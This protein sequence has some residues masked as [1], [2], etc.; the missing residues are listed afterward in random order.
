VN[1]EGAIGVAKENGALLSNG[2]AEK[3]VDVSD[4]KSSGKGKIK[5]FSLGNNITRTFGE[6][7]SI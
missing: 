5:G 3:L 4:T 2:E 7:L 1:A 6:I